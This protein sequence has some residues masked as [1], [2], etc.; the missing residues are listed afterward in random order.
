MTLC[1]PRA[2]PILLYSKGGLNST[3][4]QG[5]SNHTGHPKNESQNDQEFARHC[6]L[7]CPHPLGGGGNG[8]T[9]VNSWVCYNEGVCS[10]THPNTYYFGPHAEYG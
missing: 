8:H 10:L 7:L 6:S 4:N 5:R 3:L 9:L 2:G 1:R